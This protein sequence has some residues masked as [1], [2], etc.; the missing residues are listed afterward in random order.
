MFILKAYLKIHIWVKPAHNK[1]ELNLEDSSLTNKG[2]SFD[3]SSGIPR[4]SL[5]E[6]LQ[7]HPRPNKSVKSDQTRPDQTRPNQTTALQVFLLKT[8]SLISMMLVTLR[9]TL[10]L[11]L[12]SPAIGGGTK[13]FWYQ[14]YNQ[15]CK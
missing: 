12:F 3:G 10:T 14:S 9:L 13:N 5:A 6:T 8:C 1:V 4:E 15:V 11:V 7:D 2:F